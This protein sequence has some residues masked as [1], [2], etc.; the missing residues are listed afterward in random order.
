MNDRA[1]ANLTVPRLLPA[2][3]TEEQSLVERMRNGEQ[4]A[5]DEFIGAYSPRV[6]AFAARRSVLDAPALEDVVQ[7][8]MIN[9]VRGLKNFRGGSALFTWL[10]QICRNHLADGRRKA[11]RQ[12]AMQSL[13]QPDGR[14]PNETL[15]ELTDFRDP[16][17]ECSRDASGNAVRRALNRLAP[18]HAS[19]LELRFGDELTVPEIARILQLSESAAES[20]LGRA[21]QAF[22]EVWPGT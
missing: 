22:R 13:D 10:C 2:W 8:T 18:H 9:G 6:A 12:P 14:N 21:R 7:I 17:E 15:A 4:L 16:L 20:R 11:E 1:I 3:T 5:F 19:I